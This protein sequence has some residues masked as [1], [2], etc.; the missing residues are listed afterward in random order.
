M[1]QAL[2]NQLRKLLGALAG[3]QK[4][5]EA[6]TLTDILHELDR[7]KNENQGELHPQMLHYLE[8]RSYEKAFHFLNNPDTPHR[9]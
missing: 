1:T 6:A 5:P 9:P 3:S 8:R 2:E 7:I 4:P